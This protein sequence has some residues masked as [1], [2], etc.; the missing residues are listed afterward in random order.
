MRLKSL[1]SNNTLQRSVSALAKSSL[2]G[3]FGFTLIKKGELIMTFA[4][5]LINTMKDKPEV[6]NFFDY[7]FYAKQYCMI[8]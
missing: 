1:I 8:L 4:E 5:I 6:I 7:L 2:I 3:G